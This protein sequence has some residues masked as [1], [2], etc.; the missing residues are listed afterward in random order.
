[1][2]GTNPVEV[3]AAQA[4]VLWKRRISIHLRC[5]E[6]CHPERS[7][8]PLFAYEDLAVNVNA[9]ACYRAAV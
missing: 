5:Q 3:L 2:P 9:H 6:H 4:T 7:E 1:V 8:G